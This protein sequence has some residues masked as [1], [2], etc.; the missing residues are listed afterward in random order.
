M[1]IILIHYYS[2]VLLYKEQEILI[3]LHKKIRVT[4]IFTHK[5]DSNRRPT[6]IHHLRTL[7]CQQNRPP[8]PPL[9]YFN[10]SI[11]LLLLTLQITV[12]S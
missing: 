2:L 5:K 10:T 8:P 7:R 3:Q 6:A 12:T 9:Q 11:M 4:A 1:H